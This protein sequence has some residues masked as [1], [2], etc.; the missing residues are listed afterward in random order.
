M[1]LEP[2]GVRRSLSEGSVRAHS[3]HNCPVSLTGEYKLQY[4][5]NRVRM[6][7]LLDTV[8]T[9]RILR[10]NVW[11]RMCRGNKNIFTA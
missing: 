6:S 8:A 3:N 4:A 10:K 5:V 1:K 2:S 9:M 7:F 11:D